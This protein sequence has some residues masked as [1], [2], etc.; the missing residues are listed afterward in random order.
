MISS[1]TFATIEKHVEFLAGSH[2]DQ[3][4]ILHRGSRFL[5]PCPALG[6]MR[7]VINTFGCWKVEHLVLFTVMLVLDVTRVDGRVDVEF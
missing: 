4:D 2:L 5:A 7:W 3:Q 6:L 1:D